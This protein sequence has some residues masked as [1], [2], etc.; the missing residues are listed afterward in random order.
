MDEGVVISFVNSVLAKDTAKAK[1]YARRV[2][3]ELSAAL[4][5]WIEQN[6]LENEK[7]P[8]HPGATEVYQKFLDDR[9]KKIQGLKRK[10]DYY[11]DKAQRANKIA[12]TYVLLTVVF[13]VVMF[14]CGVAPKHAT[15]RLS[16]VMNIFSAII[17]LGMLIV[18]FFIM[19]LATE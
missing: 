10:G 15:V 6:P 16:F 8:L 11:F 14:L 1:F 2:K 9:Y 3:P 18:L 13:S 5:T 7:A 4:K 12:D 19:P 17:C